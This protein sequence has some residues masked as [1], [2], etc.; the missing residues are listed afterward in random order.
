MPII[1]ASLAILSIIKGFVKLHRSFYEASRALCK[2]SRSF[3][4]ASMKL[5]EAYMLDNTL[6][7]GLQAYYKHIGLYI[8]FGYI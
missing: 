8:A 6:P 3:I 7:L 4:E 5:H 1:M 2:A